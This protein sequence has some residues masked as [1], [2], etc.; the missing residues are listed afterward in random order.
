MRQPPGGEAQALRAV[1]P[2]AR[3]SLSPN[4]SAVLAQPEICR[5]YNYF[6]ELNRVTPRGRSSAPEPLRALPPGGA[7]GRRPRHRGQDRR[8][9]VA[10]RHSRRRG[11]VPRGPRRIAD[12]DRCKGWIGRSDQPPGRPLVADQHRRRPGAG[13]CSPTRQ[14]S[15]RL[16]SAIDDEVFFI[17]DYGKVF[18][19]WSLRGGRLSRW[20]EAAH[21][22]REISAPQR[23]EI[24]LTTIEADGDALRLLRLP[25]APLEQR[26]AARRAASKPSP[27]PSPAVTT[28]DRPY[29]PLS[30]LLPRSWLPLIQLADGMAAVGAAT[31]GQDALARP[32]IRGRRNVRS[33]AAASSS[34]TWRTSTT[35]G[36]GCCSTGT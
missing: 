23:G 13:R 17:A 1:E 29:S 2:D 4:G 28:A 30:S 20:T 25:E 11:A 7:A 26:D 15:T 33:N 21:G 3:L 35:D 8:R 22:V 16:A 19:V 18:N 27:L 9:P 14:R 32:P 24:L 6:Y 10:G 12:R 34:P 5:N 31:F 36:T